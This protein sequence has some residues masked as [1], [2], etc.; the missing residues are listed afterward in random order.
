[1]WPPNP[2][3]EIQLD[4]VWVDI[5]RDV[6]VEEVLAIQRGRAD[7]A[8]R[9]DPS[10]LSLLLNNRHG[11]YSPRNPLGPYY[12]QLG[13]NTPLRVRV[14]E[15]PEEGAVILRDTFSRT[16]SPDGWGTADTGQPWTVFADGAT[17]DVWVGTG[18]GRMEVGTI[19]SMPGARTPEMPADVDARWSFSLSQIPRGDMP[20]AYFCNLEFRRQ[21]IGGVLHT[22]RAIV[23]VRVFSGTPDARCRVSAHI[24]TYRGAT[25]ANLTPIDYVAEG[26]T[27][28]AGEE[29]TARVL[30][31]GPSVKF[32]VWAT[33]EAEPEAWIAQGW[34]ED[35]VG[36]GAMEFLTMV[37]TQANLTALP[38]VTSFRDITIREPVAP[39]SA[40]RF[41]GEVSSWPSR[42]DLSDSDVWVPIAAAGI[43]RRLGQG[44][45]PLRST[46]R[47]VLPTYR[48]LAYWPMEDGAQ[49]VQAAEGTDGAVGP[50]TTSG[51][52]FADEDSLP[53]SEALPTV[54]PGARIRS[55][56]I[57]ALTTGSWQAD[58]LVRMGEPTEATTNQ[59]LLD[60][61]SSTV[62]VVVTGRRF[63]DGRPI[64]AAY[65]YDLDG[66][67]LG[68]QS[69]YTDQTTAPLIYGQWVRLR[70]LAWSGSPCTTRVDFID[71]G[72]AFRGAQHTYTYSPGVGTPARVDTTFGDL[73]DLAVGHITVWGARYSL[74]Y[75]YPFAGFAGE[76]TAARLSRLGTSERVPILVVGDASTPLGTEPAGTLLDGVGSATDADLGVPG[77]P[78]D[79]LG[80]SYRARTT[81]YNQAPAITLDYQAG[82]I[83]DPVEPQ[84]D[85]QATRND[86]EVKRSAG[87]SYQAVDEDGPLG[88]NRVG[89]YDESVTLSLWRD[90]QVAAQAGWRLHLGTVDELRWPTIHLNLANT[91]MRPLIPA[92]LALDAGDRIRIL[93]PP[94][95]TQ[96]THLDLIV[97]GYEERIGVYAWDL[98]LTC[99]PA[100]AWTVGVVPEQDPPPPP[101]AAA[102]S[103][104]HDAATTVTAAATLPGDVLIVAQL[105]DWIDGTGMA[106]SPTCPTLGAWEL[107]VSVPPP[108]G[109]G[110]HVRV[111]ATTVA[112]AGA[113]TITVP[114]AIPQGSNN[115]VQMWLVRGADQGALVAAGNSS[116]A[117]DPSDHHHAPSV[118]MPGPGLLVCGWLTTSSNAVY[119][120][121]PGMTRA[122]ADQVGTSSAAMPAYQAVPAAGATGVRTATVA[123]ATEGTRLYGAYTVGAPMSL[124]TLPTADP[125]R[126]DTAGSALAAPVSATDT[127]LDVATTQGPPWITTVGQP[128]DFPVD[129]VLGGEV[130]RVTGI[131]AGS[132]ALAGA[133]AA[134]TSP[135]TAYVAPSVTAPGDSLLVCAWTTFT[136]ASG[137]FTPPGSMTAVGT[138]S[139]TWSVCV[140]ATEAIA[141]GVTGTRTL[142]G[143]NSAWSATSVAARGASGAPVVEQV[144]SHRGGLGEDVTLTTAPA[145]AG[146]WLLAVHAWDWVPGD[147]PL[148]GAPS[149]GGWQ[150]VAVSGAPQDTTSHTRVWARRVLAD[151]PQTVTFGGNPN[152]DDNH[153]HLFV[154]SGV[155]PNVSGQAFTVARSINNIAKGHAAGTDVR[156]A[157]PLIVAL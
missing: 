92:L 100:S 74:A 88:V 144:L 15:L 64:V 1:V 21:V 73:G 116:Y 44:A 138:T 87:S 136:A 110:P 145:A 106:T 54:R 9:A 65:T 41:S 43:G 132:P 140:A 18:A 153:V 86:V 146:W 13:R 120:P 134:T 84:D 12:G 32:K 62:R 142:T 85:D 113:H 36:P 2:R 20:G 75:Y 77:E 107:L 5:T 30:A 133:G 63:S 11:R 47:R 118:T 149:G 40:L 17:N 45:K 112:T 34:V 39:S 99:T 4:G 127:L 55:G 150:E 71:S 42:W 135:G 131:A 37:H 139:G 60:I 137:T 80:L 38:A 79:H 7:E 101:V 49:A 70:V 10:S 61:T 66:N 3:V 148:P 56:P 59:T 125:D 82:T 27:Y 69:L 93:N 23:S 90:D 94:H 122:L 33:G 22:M 46:L 83:F 48:P 68:T 114:V 14:G 108:P 91:R 98:T 154:L 147:P 78:R 28:A 124:P 16:V 51:L 67:L 52:V 141:A 6:R 121:P 105:W 129:V 35:I 57:R 143:P 76:S 102:S 53:T 72:E 58:M 151:G 89:R 29:L 31:V 119:T 117:V 156:L 81:L 104:V 115:Q 155:A 123:P 96:A 130:V 103:V 109:E 111:W 128:D 97:Q 126:V 25:S 26:V 24:N 152:V 95:W 19:G 8:A 157:Q 50:L